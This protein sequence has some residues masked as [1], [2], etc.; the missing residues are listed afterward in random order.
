[1]GYCEAMTST[2]LVTTATTD[3]DRPGPHL[4]TLAGAWL[5]SLRTDNTRTAYAHDLDTFRAWAEGHGVEVVTA[6]RPALDL[7]RLH[8]EAEG[9]TPSTIARYLSALASFYA[10]A[11]D[12]GV[13]GAN[14]AARLARPRT[15]DE[16]PTLGLDRDEAAAFLTAARAAGPRDHAVACLLILNGLRISEVLGLDLADLTTE[17]GHR[18][19][20]IR[21]KGGKVRRAA[22]APRTVEAVEAATAGR[23]TGPVIAGPTGEPLSRHAGARIVARLARRAGLGAKRITPHSCRHTMVTL[24]LDAGVPL[25]DVQD[26]AGHASPETTRRYDRARHSLDRHATYALASFL[27]DDQ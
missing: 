4:P 6:G 10:Y 12:A 22:L 16:S 25:R 11:V 8:L 23:T 26:A 17:R 2:E 3:L 18:V 27:G 9:L 15:S 5:A 20:K 24:A 19:A 14:P 21:G 1:M 13:L 7:Y